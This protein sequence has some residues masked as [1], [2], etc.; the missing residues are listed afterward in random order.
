M[1]DTIHELKPCPFCGGSGEIHLSCIGGFI[2]EAYVSC[3]ECGCKRPSSHYEH[4]AFMPEHIAKA[5]EN[6][7]TRPELAEARAEIE[8]LKQELRDNST[9]AAR[10]IVPAEMAL[11]DATAELVRK[12]KLIEQMRE[13][14]R[15]ALT[16]AR[17]TECERLIKAALSAAKRGE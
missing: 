10:Q 15:Y 16:E 4:K 2:Y 6:W 8:R 3:V 1:S 11:D 13:A 17:S 12:D 5:V 7:N 9:Q 14:L